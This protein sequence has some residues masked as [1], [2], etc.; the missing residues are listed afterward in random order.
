MTF[1]LITVYIQYLE[2]AGPPGFG[3]LAALEAR[4]TRPA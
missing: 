4:R 2:G 3:T 1:G